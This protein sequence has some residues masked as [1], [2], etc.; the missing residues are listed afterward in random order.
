MSDNVVRHNSNMA[1]DKPEI[2]RSIYQRIDVIFLHLKTYTDFLRKCLKQTKTTAHVKF[3]T[4]EIQ[5]GSRNPS[6]SEVVITRRCE[7]ISTWSQRLQ[8]SFR[9]RPIP[10]HL[11]QH[12]Q[13]M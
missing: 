11:R 1:A 8:H 12:R 7:D 10:L 4:F 6:K 3:L 2:N 13:T 5:T 9:A